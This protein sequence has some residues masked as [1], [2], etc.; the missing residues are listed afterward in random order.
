MTTIAK[1]H[2][3]AVELLKKHLI[4]SPFLDARILLSHVCNYHQ[5]EILLKAEEL[6]LTTNQYELFKKLV[7]K[8]AIEKIPIS[9]II[10][11]KEFF[12]LNFYVD[13]NVLDP[14][15]DSEIL[16]EMI[17][18]DYQNFENLNILEIGTGSS[19]L[20]VA[21]I[22]TLNNAKATA[23]DISAKALEVAN[24]NITQHNLSLKIKTLQSNLF[25]SLDDSNKFNIIFSNP[26]Y[27][28][29]NE[30]N[31]LDD[32]VRKYDPISA[33]D[34]GEDGLDFYRLIAKNAKE[35]L[36]NDGSLFL[37]IGINQFEQIKIIFEKEGW[38]FEKY[39]KDLAGII[40]ALKFKINT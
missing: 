25:S 35:Y 11:Q 32:E 23:L 19:C 15:P 29:T 36:Q 16:V 6:S 10:N 1:A 14:R 30:I 8:R 17:I 4:A 31:L 40:R 34:G 37:E 5:N 21:I 22:K 2:K 26:P 12:G 3:E 13:E 28:P 9:K 24:K 18:S 7:L 39:Q 38:H 20:V 33:L 27:I